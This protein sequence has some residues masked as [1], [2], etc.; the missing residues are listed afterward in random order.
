M[1]APLSK[2]IRVLVVDDSV[3]IRSLMT[4]I[5]SQDPDI[6]VIG[7]A[8]DPFVARTMLIDQKPDVMTLDVEMPKM[9]GITFLTKVM[10]HFPTRTI[11]ISSLTVAGAPTVMKALEAGAMEVMAKPALDVTRSMTQIADELRSRVKAVARSPLPV[12]RLASTA[13]RSVGAALEKTTHAICAIATSTG[14]TEALKEVIPYLPAGFPGTA[15]V[16]HM[17]PV[18]TK[19]FAD[20]LQR[21]TPHLE[22][23]EARDGDRLVPG[24]VLFAPGNYHM[25]IHRSGAHSIAR[26]HQQPTLHGVRPAADYLLK[27]VAHAAGSNAMGAVLTGMGKDGAAGLLAMKQAGAWTITQS[28]RTC[29]VYGMPREADALKAGCES[30]DLENVADHLVARVRKHEREVA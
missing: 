6:E 12:R 21:M 24:L 5:L 7:S 27:T 15:V 8:P 19:T 13:S 4:R 10:E 25:E 9:D 26:L 18:F 30:V 16:I 22:I 20:S 17:P 29:V 3:V 1:V 14:G 2:K 23:R 28:E 11:I